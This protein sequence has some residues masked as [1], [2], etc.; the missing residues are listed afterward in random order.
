[1]YLQRRKMILSAVL[2]LSLLMGMTFINR[3]AGAASVP[4]VLVPGSATCAQVAPGTTEF[5]IEPVT[6]GSFSDG[7][8]S[9]TIHVYDTNNGQVFDFTSNLS[10]DAVIVKGGP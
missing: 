5:K 4:P 2:I 7:T 6:E 10:V 3:P 8:L 1:M 9:V